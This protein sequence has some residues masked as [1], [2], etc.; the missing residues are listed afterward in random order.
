MSL[1]SKGVSIRCSQ[2]KDVY[3]LQVLTTLA[4]QSSIRD[5][6]ENSE[7]RGLCAYFDIPAALYIKG[8]QRRDVK[9]Y[10]YMRNIHA[11]SQTGSN[12][13]ILTKFSFP[14]VFSESS[15]VACVDVILSQRKRDFLLRQ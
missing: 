10:F 15:M 1:H 7:L 5:D 3:R 12:R 13:L 4:V 11:L 9:M 2:N 6:W 14:S 8:S